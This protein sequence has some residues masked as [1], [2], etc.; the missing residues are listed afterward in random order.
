MGTMGDIIGMAIRWAIEALVAV[1]HSLFS[2]LISLFSDKFLIGEEMLSEETVTILIDLGANGI[3]IVAFVA[4]FVI[5]G[6]Q[7]SKVFIGFLGL[8]QEVEEP[9]KVAL[10]F[11]FFGLLIFYIKDIC[12]FIIDGPVT[13]IRNLILS[14]GLGVEDGK[15]IKTQSDQLLEVVLPNDYISAFSGTSM[16]LVIF[17]ALVT[18]Y[19]DYRL[20]FF[21]LSM[22]QKYVNVIIYII[23]SPFAI[24]C[25]VSRATSETL[26]SWTK[27]FAGGIA[28]QMLQIILL[29]IIMVYG[30]MLQESTAR[31]WSLVFVYLAVAFV[32]DKAEEIL[33]EFGLSGGIKFHL[34]MDSAKSG[35]IKILNWL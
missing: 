21:V 1:I 12:C 3:K 22:V 9:W 31:N 35:L 30:K 20:F 13:I 29:K 15:I 23:I 17:K 14:I 5:A 27:L 11:V 28:I 8:N 6:W 19:V 26:K 32:M 25:G 24:A 7:M 34:G 16:S 33:E 10:K 4:A 2:F 18:V